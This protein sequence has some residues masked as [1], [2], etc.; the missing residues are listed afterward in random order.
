MNIAS[1]NSSSGM[2]CSNVSSFKKIGS[3]NEANTIY[4]R[5]GE[6]TYTKDM[7]LDDD[8]IVTFEEFKDYCKENNLSSDEIKQLLEARQLWELFKEMSKK[9]QEE[10]QE[11]K[12]K[13]EIYARSGDENYDE[14][15]DANNDKKVTYDEYMKY[16]KENSKEEDSKKLNKLIDAYAL[17]KIEESEIKIET[18]A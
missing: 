2:N 16:C 8:G 1:V 5:K 15:M 14:A 12:D 9:R 10:Q 17:K 6:P 7:D 11:N 3:Q 13:E 18:E 4:A